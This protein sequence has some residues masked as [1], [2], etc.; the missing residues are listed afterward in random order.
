[1]LAPI[2]RARFNPVDGG[3]GME[4]LGE[5]AQRLGDTI[6]RV[7]E[8]QDRLDAQ[9]DNAGAKT[10]DV[11]ARRQF[12]AVLGEF[13]AKEGLNA[14]SARPDIEKRLGEIRSSIAARATSPRMQRMLSDSLDMQAA[15][16]FGRV[17]R[18]AET[19]VARAE[20]TATEAR[21]ESLGNAAIYALTPE[22]RGRNLAAAM[23][24]VARLGELNGDASEVTALRQMKVESG[25]HASVIRNLVDGDNLDGAVEYEARNAARMI[26]EDRAR[27]GRMMM[28]PLQ[29]RQANGDAAAAMAGGLPSDAPGDGATIGGAT[30]DRVFQSLL[31]QESG[32][33][34]GAVGP[35]TEWG[36]AYGAAQVLDSTARGVAKRLGIAW[37]PD[38]MR[39]KSK[40]G[41]AYQVKI[42]EAYF[43]EGLRRH[44]GDMRK[45]L[46]YYHGGPDQ[47]KWGSKTRAYA[48]Q[49]MARAG[50]GSAPLPGAAARRWDVEGLHSRLEGAA[51][52]QGWSPERLS[53]A[54]RAADQVVNRDEGLLRRR[55]DDAERSA[56]EAIDGLEGNRLTSMSQLPGDVRA[57]LSPQSRMRF[58][59]MVEAN[60]RPV[61][62]SA[63]G[64]AAIELSV[65]SA[66]NKDAFLKEDLRRYRH[67]MTPGEY[68]QLRERQAKMQASPNVELPHS[69][70]WSTINFY[71][72]DAGVDMSAK[73]KDE[74]DAK[75]SE[76]RG[77][78]MALFQTMQGYLNAVTQGK[79]APTDAE[80]K[81]AI[82]N[83]VMPVRGDSGDMVPRFRA[84]DSPRN[85]VAM[86]ESERNRIKALLQR[87]GLP[88]DDR[89]IV[90][91]YLRGQ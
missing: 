38:L 26:D 7:A 46:M 48:D 66:S 62:P 18:H 77:E 8:D 19:Q 37:Q 17:S 36:N 53:R 12:D 73:R 80:Y 85:S 25:V 30:K 82:D 78:G 68:A 43:E 61:E 84:S 14:G 6:A 88:T 58:E 13:G 57:S 28:D 32:N 22:D 3:G 51:N 69:K 9:L 34:A 72:R 71:G 74:S 23:G 27:V 21:A 24:E 4:A 20:K 35:D 41:Y 75:F 83:A 42:G 54:K 15:E 79:R 40:E 45:A 90:S 39:A 5:G 59:S 70:L 55:E 87:R 63:N 2:T 65:L 29:D 81:A 1:M 44:G 64:D 89:T 33:R 56:L 67:Q 11:E 60:N 52:E 47:K 16:A 31:V 76:R 50:G 10:L 91:V 86:K 49:V